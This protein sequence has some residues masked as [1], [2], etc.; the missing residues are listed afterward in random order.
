MPD[1]NG[2]RLVNIGDPIYDKDAVS[3]RVL[4]NKLSN[5]SGGSSV[6]SGGTVVGDTNFKGNLSG[7]TY[8]SGSTPLTTIITNIASEFGTGTG[9]YLPLSGGT[10][11]GNLFTPQVNSNKI[12]SGGTDLYNIF[13]TNA[14]LPTSISI[15]PGLNTYTGGTILSPTI[16]ISAA[17]LSYLSANTISGSTLY[18][19]NTDLNVFFNQDRAQINTKANLS[20]ATFTGNI[21]TP[22]LSA[23]T[24]SGGTLYSGSTSLQTILASYQLTGSSL[25]GNYLPLSGGTV[26]G[27]TIFTS[28]I[29]AN[30]LNVTNYI[31]F[32]T[33]TTTPA[34]ISGRVYYDNQSH[35]LAYFPDIN[36]N[37][38]VEMGQQL[39]IRGYNATGTL[40]P[41][42][43]ALSIQSAT[44]GL[45][46]FTLAANI[47]AGHGQL[48]GLAASDIPNASNGLALSQGIL[49][50]LTLNTFSV[51]DILYVSPFSA[52]T[53]VAGTSSFP[54]TARTNQVGYVIATG[55]STGEIYVSINNEDENLTLTDIE[56]NILEG[57]VISTGLYNYTG[58]TQGTGQTIN[59]AAI[60]GWIAYNTYT[61]ATLP[62]V[63]EIIYTSGTNIPLTYLNSADA[64]YVLINSAS[65]IVQQTTFPT[66]QQRRQNIYLGKVV[67]PNRS[68][69]TSINQTVDFDVSPMSA[70]RDL[71]TPLKLINQGI[72][73]SPN[74]VNLSINTSAGVL[75]GNGIG[76]VTSQLNPDSISISGT[77]PTTFQYR[78]QLGP[79]TGGT[80]P[81]TGN[82]TLI[83][84]A[85]YD[86]NGVVTN[87]GGGSNSSTN[88]RIYIFPTGLVR[89]QYGQTVYSNLAAAVAGSQTESF[90]EYANNRD[91]GILI[92]ILS[93]NKNATQLSNS[94]QAVFNLVSKFGELLGGTGGLSTTTL[95]QAYDNS[96]TPEIVINA[97]LDGLSIQNGTGNADNVTH[98][99]EA[100]N[101]AG[102]TTSFIRAD[103]YISGTT[104]QSVGFLANNNGL[105]ANTISATTLSGGT[106]YS[107]ST[108]LGNLLTSP[109][110][111][112][113]NTKANLSGATFTGNINTPSLSA[114]T[115]SG[116]TIY[117]GSTSLQTILA[118]YQLTG[119]STSGN[120]LPLS[121]GTV[122][123]VTNFTGGLSAL[124]FSANTVILSATS[125][126][127][128]TV[129]FKIVDASGS[130]ILTVQGD[131]NIS[132]GTS[133][134]VT[135]TLLIRKNY[136]AAHDAF[137]V[138]N[139]EYG[140]TL[141]KVTDN[142][143]SS[144]ANGGTIWIGGV[145]TN[146]NNS[147]QSFDLGYYGLGSTYADAAANSVWLNGQG[148]FGD[149][150]GSM[151]ISRTSNFY[152]DL[153]TTKQFKIDT[154]GNVGIG[155]MTANTASTY[156]LLLT[157]TGTAPST[158]VTN[159]V[160]LYGQATTSGG[161]GLFI[162]TPLNT[163]HTFADNV[164]IN[165]NN[166]LYNLDVSGTVRATSITA[167]TISAT[168]FYSG[169]T[170][171]STIISSI[172]SASATGVTNLSNTVFVS[173]LVSDLTGVKYNISAPYKTI[174]TALSNATTGDTIFVMAGTYA[175]TNLFKDGVNYY[176][177]NGANIVPSAA[178]SVFLISGQTF[179][180]WSVDGFLSVTTAQNACVF[181]LRTGTTSTNYNLK[182]KQITA[183]NI[184]GSDSFTFNAPVRLDCPANIVN[185]T[186]D[187]KLT[188]VLASVGALTLIYDNIAVFNFNGNIN[189]TSTSPAYFSNTQSGTYRYLNGTFRGVG[190]AGTIYVGD[191]NYTTINGIVSNTSISS[192]VYAF[193]SNLGYLGSM[194]FNGSIYGNIW[195]QG[196]SVNN[197][198]KIT[199]SIY[200]YS[201]S[202]QYTKISSG[203]NHID[204]SIYGGSFY[205]EG[206]TNV[207]EG[208]YNLF[209]YSYF[210][211]SAHFYQTAGSTYYKAIGI[212]NG[213]GNS[214]NYYIPAITGGKL[215][216]GKSAIFPLMDVSS[217]GSNTTF[218][219]LLSGGTLVCEGI[220][221]YSFTTSPLALAPIEY[222]SGTLVLDGAR[223]INR[224]TGT[225][226]CSISA[227]TNQNIKIYGNSFANYGTS[228]G[229]LTN[230]VTGGGSLF[231][232]S[233]V[234][235]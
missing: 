147:S 59:I 173:T 23:T 124:T 88:Q 150:N 2:Q 126:T 174:T 19:G 160:Q 68:T 153:G 185:V 57:N 38:K 96:T 170:L 143:T 56:R 156:T 87:V 123:G 159:T 216:I 12:L 165:T 78:T 70:I 196:N 102:A 204:A 51:G 182:F 172:S 217:I 214:R 198:Q 91:N 72:I 74:G 184:T 24:L 183:T 177:E 73:P 163:T 192:G 45:P 65:T 94:A 33:G 103:G 61:Y 112:Q 190:G 109:I 50:G 210:T 167:T 71:W 79:I 151:A 26:T 213:S 115:L 208:N 49:S 105:T 235:E 29:T 9:I 84:P 25:T 101:A 191:R 129:P 100:Q 92:G 130:N 146:F 31:D 166:P 30:T 144:I 157:T 145:L 63:R 220:I 203:N 15:Q 222:I 164:G 149:N 225:T 221:D 89:I 136:G 194:N 162:K 187:I 64:T 77:S 7:A 11:T 113:L 20:G 189:S 201:S 176:F 193:Y 209:G 212:L 35:S 131:T 41:K 202:G 179:N 55:T 13:L 97:T 98:V 148:N 158:G 218:G 154:K 133:T 90:V 175:E 62:D 85:H 104:F 227:T 46:N 14:A 197:S 226:S 67:H 232:Y 178:T 82:T 181:D 75:W 155:A 6:F 171:L 141:F 199:G 228:G 32:N 206:G 4:N 205:V 108:E 119:T 107:G 76:W 18:S 121:G 152:I 234:T 44:N 207:L 21:N 80:A 83:D 27:G 135:S 86:N 233:G 186:G 17:T 99:L 81:Y 161:T 48:V 230:L 117:S 116:G 34:N 215:H 8:F 1:F 137:T 114:T 10:M 128:T 168:T 93:V 110:Y 40:I 200:G 69:I 66:P 58:M 139:G 180:D 39:Y 231:V 53:Y 118:S 106:F 229:T 125:S 60:N 28:G 127:S 43:S 140:G 132:I 54:F 223:I 138:Q 16:N 169:A 22:S 47:H 111:S 36:Q 211:N 5:L 52:G 37:V 120:Y 219:M 42:G 224:Q 122:T 188:S 195:L 142:H 134:G 95:Q 3:L